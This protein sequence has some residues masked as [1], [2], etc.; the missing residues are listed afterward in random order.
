MLLAFSA[1]AL[2]QSA[3]TL[4]R[5]IAYFNNFQDAKAKVT[6]EQVL[7]ANLAGLNA[8][9]A[10][11]YL[12]LIAVNALDSKRARAEFMKAL[13]IEPTVEVPYEASPKARLVFDQAQREFA[14]ESNQPDFPVARQPLPVE[15]APV[16]ATQEVAPG[17]SHVPAYVVGALG[18]V[19]LGTGVG[20]GVWQ[21]S[22]LKITD[23]SQLSSAQSQAGTQGLVADICFGVGGALAVTSVILFVT[24]L[25]R[26]GGS[27]ENVSLRLSAAPGGASAVLSF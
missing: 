25:S 12:G 15:P 19:I 24:E 14:R 5:A 22:T 2:A 3:P 10:H 21:S 7:A 16:A 4:A 8:A 23:A 17:S 13:T 20:F 6:L 9:K 18:L 1:P 11:V 27:T 26:G